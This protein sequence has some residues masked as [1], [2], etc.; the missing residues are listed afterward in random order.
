VLTVARWVLFTVSVA[1]IGSA[2]ARLS[3][4][5]T[6][7]GD[8]RLAATGALTAAIAVAETLLLGL[9]G[10]GGNALVIAGAAVV[11]WLVVRLTVTAVGPSSI[12]LARVG[13]ARLGASSRALLGA[14]TAVG[15]TEAAYLI[16]R[17]V[18]GTDGLIYHLADPAIWVTDGHPG[19]M[20]ATVSGLP[21]QAYPKTGEVLFSWAIGTARTPVVTTLV[22]VAAL[23]LA[24]VCSW[25]VL[26]RIGVDQWVAVTLTTS[27]VLCPVVVTQLSGPN[28]D[29]L[30]LAWVLCTAALCLG[31]INESAL[32]PI[33]LV[34]GGVAVGTKTTAIPIVVVLL[35]V[36]GW[37]TR[38]DLLRHRV[39]LTL[40]SATA[41]GVGVVWYLQDLA[42]YHAPLY[43]F[44]RLPSGPP[45]PP[46]ITALGARFLRN[47][48]AAVRVATATGYA[49]GLGAGLVLAAGVVIT[50]LLLPTVR[51]RRLRGLIA[52]TVAA[53]TAE[54]LVWSAAP[55][56]GASGQPG[57]RTLVLAGIR[58]LLPGL[59]LFAVAVG[60][61]SRAGGVLGLAARAIAVVAV[62]ADL[63]ANRSFQLGIR[64]HLATIIAAALVG[65]LVAVT[66]GATH[67]LSKWP[68]ATPRVLAGGIAVVLV[69]TM[70]AATHGYLG[71]H[72]TIARAAHV[73]EPAILS[74]L[75]QQPTWSNGHLPIASGPVA[76]ALFAGPTFNHPLSVITEQTSCADVQ[77]AARR[78]WVVLPTAPEPPEVPGATSYDRSR[79]LTGEQPAFSAGGVAVYRPKQ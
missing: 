47:P 73:D 33:A 15:I 50:A 13:W 46:V 1:G 64:P 26:R 5:A 9:V 75:A 22:M 74:W 79:C 69:G 34:A 53:A 32:L 38:H 55:F 78:G 29:L 16:G 59:A 63:W 35:A 70:S 36:T 11:T 42:V 66:V 12:E 72:L 19:S 49:R 27:L 77:A 58:Y 31:A 14:A 56:T 28:T 17:P 54:A 44:S 2:A 10:L 25:S 43:P 8:L 48:A 76:D 18:I 45:L 41:L 4:R 21:I 7:A 67:T 37:R 68:I 61:A 24:A 52:I 57:S 62:I 65:G 39:G 30:T 3:R 71:R 40:A 20:H 23:G 60:L 6:A 51:E